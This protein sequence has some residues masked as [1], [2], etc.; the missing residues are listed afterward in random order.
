MRKKRAFISVSDKTGIV[1]FAREIELLGFEIIST[2]GTAKALE[3]GGLSVISVSDITGFPECLDG[4]VKTLHPK[5]HG[6]ILA[7][8]SNEEHMRQLKEMDIAPIDLVVV[9]LYPFRETVMKENVTLEEAIENIDIGGP[10]MLRAAAK[11]Y[12]DVVVIVE[13]EDYNMVLEAYKTSGDVSKTTRLALAKKVFD[14]TASYDAL[15]SDYLGK[16]T[17]ERFP[18]KLT[19]T[20]EKVQDLRYGENAHQRAMYYKELGKLKGCLHNAVQLHGKELSFN[21]IND[22]D[23]ALRLL[24]EIGGIVAV[25]V[26]HT[27]PCGVAVGKDIYEAYMKAYEADPVSIFGGIIAVSREVDARTA[28]E[29]AKTFL[30]IIIAPSFSPEALEILTKKKNL[31]LLE[32]KDIEVMPDKWS[33]DIKKVNGGLLAQ[34]VDRTGNISP[35]SKNIT[36]RKI[37]AELLDDIDFAWKVAMYTKSNAIVVVKNGQTLGIGMGQTSRIAAMEQA[38]AQAGEKAKGAIV[39]SDAYFPFDDCVV[40]AAKYDVEYIVQPGGSVRDADSIAACD[41]FNIAMHFTGVRHFK[42]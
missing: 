38:L 5:V 34:D 3:S 41:R 35:T 16:V 17:G 42:H 24:K 14:H 18:R 29:M 6:G 25:A 28:E 7:I 1:D 22:A 13:I 21:N 11:N 23:S 15:I 37:P 10:S 2:G 26:K 27:N 4:R 19:L 30:E 40:L 31:R 32:L 8:R 20:F 39:A 9:N 33:L 12:Q 36:K